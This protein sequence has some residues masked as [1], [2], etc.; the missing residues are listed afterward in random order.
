MSGGRVRH[1]S[2]GN[3]LSDDDSDRCS[4]Q[5]Y[6]S[7][8]EGSFEV[9]SFKVNADNVFEERLKFGFRGIWVILTKIMLEHFKNQIGFI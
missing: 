5:S 6:D 9:R 8:F 4:L 3:A 1:E 2:F 7:R